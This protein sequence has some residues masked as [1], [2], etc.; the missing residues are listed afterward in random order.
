MSENKEFCKT[1]F[2]VNKKS[3]WLRGALSYLFIG[4]KWGVII[5]VG[6]GVLVISFTAIRMGAPVGGWGAGAGR[7]FPMMGVFTVWCGVLGFFLYRLP[8][9]FGKKKRIL[10]VCLSAFICTLILALPEV[11]FG[12]SSENWLSGAVCFGLF[13]AFWSILLTAAN[14]FDKSGSKSDQSGTK[15]YTEKDNKGTR[16]ETL[17]QAAN[18]WVARNVHQKFDPFALYVFDKQTDATQALLEL[19][20]MHAAE[21]TGKI[22]CTETLIFGCYQRDD[23]KYEAIVCGDDLSIEVWESARMS[24]S[25]HGGVKKNEQKPEKSQQKRVLTKESGAKKVKFVREDRKNCP[26]G[27]CVYRIHKAPDA[28]SAKAF[29]EENAVSKSLYYIVVETPEGNYCRDR[30]GIYKE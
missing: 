5:S 9:H 26:A 12:R 10:W 28:A 17:D 27:M 18:Y 13:G 19:D 3:G 4:L 24:F 15:R 6:F 1:S 11:I 7:F 16:H 22:V 23:G 14:Q 25:K 21:D 29:L 2:S 30:D 8:E 20:C